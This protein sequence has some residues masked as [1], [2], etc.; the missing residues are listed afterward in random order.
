M[1]EFTEQT[2][3]RVPPGFVLGEP[4]RLLVEW[5]ETQDYVGTAHD[6]DL[7]GV[8][9]GRHLGPAVSIAGY[10]REKTSSFVGSWFGDVD[11]D[12]SSWLWAFAE[13]GADGSTAALWLGVDGRTRVVHLGSGS[14]SMLTCVLA[15]DALDFVRLLAI[16]YGELCWPEDFDTPPE[17]PERTSLLREWVEQTF[18]V[19]VPRTASEIVRHPAELGDED[20]PD[21]FCRLISRLTS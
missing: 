16:G 12:P 3:A 17:E 10:S 20:T 18:N 1:G 21:P 4:L 14:G 2:L 7:Y 15:E 8:L 6:G 19:S 13:T 11:E 9:D 5:I